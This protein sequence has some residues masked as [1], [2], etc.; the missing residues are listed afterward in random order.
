M[1]GGHYQY[2]YRR[3]EDFTEELEREVGDVGAMSYMPPECVAKLKDI[4]SISTRTAALMKEVEWLMSDD[5]GP[6]SFLRNVSA[7]ERRLVES[8]GDER[9]AGP[10]EREVDRRMM[11][12]LTSTIGIGRAELRPA[13]EELCAELERLARSRKPRPDWF[14]EQCNRLSGFLRGAVAETEGE[15]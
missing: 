4:A 6:E 14:R 9:H 11:E 8:S 15:L 1:S 12:K 2:A 5:I 13:T 3:V 7:I 10:I